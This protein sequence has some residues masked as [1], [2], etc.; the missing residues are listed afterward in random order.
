MKNNDNKKISF[1]QI[2]NT[3]ILRSGAMTNKSSF[4][5]LDNLAL[6]LIENEKYDIF[7]KDDFK[8]DFYDFYHL[9]LPPIVL[10]EI[11]N[12]L[13][14]IKK[15]LKKIGN[16]IFQTNKEEVSKI[17]QLES[18]ESF[19]NDRNLLVS[20]LKEYLDKNNLKRSKEETENLLTKHIEDSLSILGNPQH[21][22]ILLNSVEQYL[23]D[24]FVKEL[25]ANYEEYYR[26][27]KNILIGRL[28]ASFI[29]D[30]ISVADSSIVFLDKLVLYL[31]TG[32]AFRLLGLD[33]YSTDVEYLDMISTL[34][35]LGAQI[36]IF[37]HVYDEVYDIINGSKYWINN[38]LYSPA[39]ASRVSE[40]FISNK[41]TVEE[42]D[43]Y[44]LTLED[45]FVAFNIEIVDANIN[46]DEPDALG[47]YEEN[48]FKAIKEQYRLT[49]GYNENKEDTYRIDAKSIYAVHK[50]RKGRKYH[51]LSDAGHILLTTNRGI[52]KVARDCAQSG[53]NGIAYA[54]TDAYFS[55]LLFFSYPSYSDETNMR[56]LIPTAYHAF[57]PSKDLLAKMESVLKELKN[58]GVMTESQVFS[59]ISNITL[60]E[61]IIAITNNDPDLFDETTPDK[62][63]EKIKN[64]AKN[65]IENTEAQ[66]DERIKEANKKTDEA[67]SLII[68]SDDKR[69]KLISELNNKD[70][71]EIKRLSNEKSK[72]EKRGTKR[73]RLLKWIF[74]FA[75]AI[76]LICLFGVVAF[77]FDYF[78]AKEC[79]WGKTIAYGISGFLAIIVSVFSFSKCISFCE[80]LAAKIIRNDK[81]NESI[82]RICDKIES[83]RNEIS[84][85]NT[86]V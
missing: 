71:N 2:C 74:V 14:S 10:G 44:L 81:Y 13:C 70:E 36:K 62:V 67:L 41:Y 4:E 19:T 60:G 59:W 28:L 8:K 32:I 83:L 33:N 20:F 37:R 1:K 55:L 35:G 77:L 21:K 11:I 85:R 5:L 23:M 56:F 3:A 39:N 42:V 17:N 65:K 57:R 29:V 76:F 48:I 34:Q 38:Y 53:N 50:L 9:E 43:E 69:K 16:D 47:V 18:L 80:Q 51:K 22:N 49:G 46:Y 82:K 26:I 24:S 6:T 27:Y 86:S 84:N 54:I 15:M 58:K 79:W 63:M 7:T 25:K 12:R 72:I 68:E 78:L 40:H 52:A 61:E 66:A 64:D 30:N 45:K 73:I 75:M 31:D